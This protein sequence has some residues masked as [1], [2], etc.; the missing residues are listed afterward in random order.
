MTLCTVARSI[1]R[2]DF[3]IF[4]QF[5]NTSQNI[6]NFLTENQNYKLFFNLN[7]LNDLLILLLLLLLLLL[8]QEQKAL[9][10]SFLFWSAHFFTLRC[11]DSRF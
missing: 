6:R 10:L 3:E 2:D 9:P 1:V 5:L 11:G 4:V 7:S 8:L